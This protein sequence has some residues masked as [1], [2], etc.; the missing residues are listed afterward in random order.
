MSTSF[1]PFV[2]FFSRIFDLLNIPGFYNH[3]IRLD[4][5]NK[6]ASIISATIYEFNQAPALLFFFFSNSFY[7]DVRHNT[8]EKIFRYFHCDFI[9]TMKKQSL[10]RVEEKKKTYQDFSY[11]VTILAEIKE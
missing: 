6:I 2:F 10:L 3:F 11:I 4:P 5:G 7:L 8:E 9:A 1:F